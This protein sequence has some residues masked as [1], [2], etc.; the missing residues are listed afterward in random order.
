LRLGPPLK[1]T[2]RHNRRIYFSKTI[3]ARLRLRH[4]FPRL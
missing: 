3:I 1:N 2:P 4:G